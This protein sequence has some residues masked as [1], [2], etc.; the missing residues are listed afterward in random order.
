MDF[1]VK[2]N[3]DNIIKL[4]E[5]IDDPESRKVYMVME[6]LSGGSLRDKLDSLK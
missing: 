2:M 5:V 4:H 1:L 3:H 6:Y